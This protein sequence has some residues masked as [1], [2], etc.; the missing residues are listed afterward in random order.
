M[1]RVGHDP[2]IS[3]ELDHGT[4]NSKSASKDVESAMRRRKKGTLKSGRSG[5]TV[6]SKKQAIAI[7]LWKR[8]ARARRSRRRREQR[9]APGSGAGNS[10]CPAFPDFPQDATPLSQPARPSATSA[11][12]S[13][14]DAFLAQK[15]K[16]Q[17][18]DLP[19]EFAAS[20][21]PESF[22]LG[23]NRCGPGLALCAKWTSTLSR[24]IVGLRHELRSV[25][26]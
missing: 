7:G 15:E 9:S 19:T 2:Q 3:D 18:G 6:K 24:R 11:A 14:A 12:M 5:K 8:A 4:Q 16:F 13:T 21:D 10:F 17:L 22:R 20:Q 25:L 23:E 1:F 26:P